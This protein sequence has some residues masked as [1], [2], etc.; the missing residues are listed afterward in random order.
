ME[1]K[2]LQVG[3]R[4]KVGTSN[5]RRLRRDQMVPGVLYGKEVDN[6]S[7]EI[8]AK[9]LQGFL[10]KIGEENVLIDVQ[11]GED[12]YTS[13]LKDVQ[14]HPLSGE[15]LH[16]D[17][18]RV[19]MKEE[20]TVTVSLVVKGAAE[21][22]GAQEGGVVETLL[23]ELEVRCLPLNIPANLELDV[24][25]LAMGEKV[26]VSDVKVPAD[27]KMVTP[28]EQTIIIVSKP[29][30]VE[31]EDDTTG[32]PEVI[33]GEAEAGEAGEAGEAKPEAAE[34][35]KADAAADAKDDKK[36]EKK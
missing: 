31:V 18:H 6:V 15:A 10:S 12:K 30:E 13:L 2:I 7:I 17:F 28:A 4:M 24:S 1:R 33:G 34:G 5:A 14:R 19:S 11:I 23:S 36:A 22:P 9:L 3:K 35:K 26:H 21:C 27:V 29:S 25:Q 20:I 16:V 32:E 8:A